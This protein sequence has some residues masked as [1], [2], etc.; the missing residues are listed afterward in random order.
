MD[1]TS[2]KRDWLA[3]AQPKLVMSDVRLSTP[4][5]ALKRLKGLEG[6]PIPVTKKGRDA[7]LWL[8]TE[9]FTLK[10]DKGGDSHEEEN[11]SAPLVSRKKVTSRRAEQPPVTH[12]VIHGSQVV[13]KGGDFMNTIVNSIIKEGVML[14][15]AM[16]IIAL[17]ST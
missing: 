17:S 6:F 1:Q 12:D 9:Q 3:Q 11:T 10:D 2:H 15:K 7:K 14:M 16:Q 13:L 8:V 5:P 4:F